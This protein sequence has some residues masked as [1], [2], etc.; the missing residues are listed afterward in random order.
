MVSVFALLFQQILLGMEGAKRGRK[1]VLWSFPTVLPTLN[2]LQHLW[3]LSV[4]GV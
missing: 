2:I 3:L 4:D 1:I